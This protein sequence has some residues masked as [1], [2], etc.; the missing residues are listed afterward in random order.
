MGDRL[1]QG[2]KMRFTQRSRQWLGVVGLAMVTTGCA[3]S[4]DPLTRAELADQA[5]SDMAALRSGQPAIDTPL[6]Q[7]EAVARAI[8]YNRDRHVASMKAALARNQL[9][10]ANFQ[11]LPSLTAAAGYTTRSEF[12]ATQSVPFID[13]S[14]RRE[15]GN[16]IFSVG[17]EK[18]R[19]T[20]GVDFTW[21]ILD[22]GLSYV[23]AKQQANQY[24][25]TVEEERKAIQNLAQETRTAYWKAVSATAL[26]D[27]VGPLMDKVNGALVNSRE[28]TRQRI[29]D[30]LTN[31]SYE[32]SLLDV[33]RAL[34][35]LRD[36]LIGSREKLA[37][38]M[39]LPPD[40]GYQLASYE[41]DELEAP[42][43]VF[44]ID[45]MENTALLQRPEILSA[46]YRK[47]IARDDVR[48]ALLQ[49]F[50]DLSLSAGYQQD[51][52]DFLRYNDWASAGASI[53]YDLL[54]IFQTK[55]KYDAAKT[56]VEVAEQQRLATALAVLTQVHLAALEYRSAREQLATSTNYLRVSRSISDLVYNQ[57][58]AGSTGQLTAIKEQLN[59]LVAELRRDLAY[60]SL[61]NAFARIYQSI[62]LDPYPKDAGHTPD[63]LAAAISRRRAAWQAGYIGV[64]I[65]PIANQGP[66]LTT[67]D[68]MTQPSFTFAEDTFTVGGD[69]TYQATSE[70]GALPSWLRFDAGTRTF[71][72]AAGAPI[73]NTPITVTAIN[74]E[75]VSASDSFVLQTNFGSS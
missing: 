28:I 15:L 44:D 69:V 34:Q 7:E 38:L 14:P 18:N 64:V 30:P 57:S 25:V 17:Q 58:Q 66:V 63:E 53:S 12:A 39:G 67:R 48:A 1:Y 65:K 21:S 75:G 60:A 68:G 49:M 37:Q 3:V 33:K 70:D 8:L 51:S 24:L 5:R 46:S 59:A 73:R 16:D 6:S 19:T 42:N 45:T 74:G 72:A 13:G 32:R 23:R 4:P 20:Y 55:A 27:R 10:T 41:A 47:R 2:E 56:S 61:Q 40:T 71:S 26:L 22:F 29:S 9:T 62:G 36:E 35:T 52:N 50:P 54:N 43:A 11:M 31:Y